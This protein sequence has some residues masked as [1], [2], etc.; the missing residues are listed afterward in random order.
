MKI[1]AKVKDTGRVFSPDVINF[2][3]REVIEDASM[4]DIAGMIGSYTFD[5]IEL[6]IEDERID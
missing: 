1:L 4:D 6:Y 3:R 2:F 5:E